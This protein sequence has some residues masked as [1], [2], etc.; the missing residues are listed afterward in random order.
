MSGVLGLSRIWWF[1]I[2][3]AALA[4]TLVVVI[5]GVYHRLGESL[6]DDYGD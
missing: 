5:L 2:G 6:P 1:I 4:V 3:L